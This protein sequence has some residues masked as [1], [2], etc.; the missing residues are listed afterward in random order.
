M[1]RGA[2]RRKFAA[3]VDFRLRPPGR[4]GTARRGWGLGLPDRRSISLVLVEDVHL[5]RLPARPQGRATVWRPR[6]GAGH[7]SPP[8][9]GL[10]EL[11]R[12][13]LLSGARAVATAGL[14]FANRA[15]RPG[16][17]SGRR[18]V[19]RLGSRLGQGL[20]RRCHGPLRAHARGVR[21]VPS[22]R[23]TSTS[24]V[25]CTLRGTRIPRYTWAT[26]CTRPRCGRS[27]TRWWRRS[28]R[29]V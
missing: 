26:S 6:R 3:A 10:P 13:S 18:R 28:T 1:A 7:A 21:V 5:R 14:A 11:R 2:R 25:R 4:H 16:E 24:N 27:P 15:P 29:R 22:P 19:A 17:A 23:R 8:L 12:D 20:R 9:M